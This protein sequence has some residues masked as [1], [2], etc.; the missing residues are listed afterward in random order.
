MEAYVAPPMRVHAAAG[1]TAK[2][3]A[4]ARA[5]LPPREVGAAAAPLG[6]ARPARASCLSGQWP[7]RRCSLAATR[8][9]RG[10][11]A[12]QGGAVVAS[13]GWEVP[14]SSAGGSGATITAAAT[15]PAGSAL[16]APCDTQVLLYDTTLRDGTQQEGISL[17]VMDKLR[18]V[19]K[20]DHFGVDYIE[21]R[22]VGVGACGGHC[23]W[24]GRGGRGWTPGECGSGGPDVW[25]CATRGD[26][27]CCA[28][29][30]PL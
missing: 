28:G 23:G 29:Y 19:E 26:G 3:H 4:T 2:S 21:G 22:S 14:P 7:R 16:D 12:A 25:S 30:W 1:A 18:V 13:V 9:R 11:P 8:G 5:W 24:R 17:S 15:A 20:L 27:L 10:R 6:A